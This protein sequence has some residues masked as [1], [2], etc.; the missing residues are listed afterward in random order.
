MYLLTSCCG[1][2]GIKLLLC[3]YWKKK[4][5]KFVGMNDFSS[6]QHVTEYFPITAHP[7]LNYYYYCYILKNNHQ[8]SRLTHLFISI[9][10]FFYVHNKTVIVFC[11]CS[12]KYHSRSSILYFKRQT[13]HR[14]IN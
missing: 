11:F 7:M 13:Q 2:K 9:G 5:V 8:E 6:H 10:T 4:K 12:I 1:M 14:L 3:C